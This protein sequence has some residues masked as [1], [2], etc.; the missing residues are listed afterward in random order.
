MRAKEIKVIHDKTED[1]L[2]R[3]VNEKLVEGWEC[4]AAVMHNP[5]MT[6]FS[7]LVWNPADPKPSRPLAPLRPLTRWVKTGDGGH[8]ER[9]VEAEKISRKAGPAVQ[10]PLTLATAFVVDE[11][12]DGGLDAD[13]ARGR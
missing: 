8:W 10:G 6:R 5:E 13:G 12:H 1:G 9:I 11:N 7:L 2:T 4:A 3:K